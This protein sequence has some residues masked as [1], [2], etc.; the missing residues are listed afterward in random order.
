[1]TKEFTKNRFTGEPL[2]KS[3]IKLIGAKSKSR[4]LIYKYFPSSYDY[5]IEPFM[6]SCTVTIGRPPTEVEILGD[7]SK[8]NTNFYKTVRDNPF[9]LYPK[10]QEHLEDL[11]KDKWLAIRDSLNDPNLDGVDLAAAYYIVNKA[12]M[13]AIV[14]FNKK[15]KCNSSYCGQTTGRGWMTWEWLWNVHKRILNTTFVNQD[16]KETMEMANYENSFAYLDPP[17]YEVFTMYDKERFN[18]EDHADMVEYLKTFKGKWLVSLNDHPEVRELYRDFFI[19]P[20]KIN[21]S[22]S[23]TAAGRGLKDEVLISNYSC[24]HRHPQIQ[25]ELE[26][27][28]GKTTRK[29]KKSSKELGQSSNQRGACPKEEV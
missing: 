18:K 11:D 14:R 21:W 20:I 19:Y 2:L 15:G 10:V 29:P 12:S 13:N 8:Y 7:I 16:W 4:D 23:Q 17:Y 3:L 22:C 27:Y 9:D 28:I 5:Y 24:E 6:G 1:M 25:L 26:R